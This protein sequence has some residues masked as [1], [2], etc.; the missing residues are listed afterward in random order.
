M[1]YENVLTLKLQG[2][3]PH[4]NPKNPP[5]YIFFYVLDHSDHPYHEKKILKPI[6]EGSQGTQ[7]SK[8]V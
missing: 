8:K 2:Q 1:D 5:N 7:V 6:L 3:K 4:Q